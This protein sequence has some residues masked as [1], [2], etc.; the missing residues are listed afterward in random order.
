[1]KDKDFQELFEIIDPEQTGYV[2]YHEFLDLSEEKESVVSIC[3]QFSNRDFFSNGCGK[4]SN[5][6]LVKCYAL[7]TGF[8]SS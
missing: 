2:D 7:H 1:M 4:M 6:V 8:Y 5:C 3:F